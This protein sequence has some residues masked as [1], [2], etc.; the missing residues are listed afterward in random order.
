MSI[1]VAA[2]L[3]SGERPGTVVLFG[4]ALALVAIVLVSQSA[5]ASSDSGDRGRVAPVH[6]SGVT[7]ALMSGVAIGFFF[8]A[9]ARTAPAAGLW[10]L[11]AARAASVALFALM[12]LASGT[13]WRMPH[14][15]LGWALAGGALDMLA[16]ALYLVATHR[17]TLSVVVTLASLYPASTVMLAWLFLGER[18]SRVQA[19]GIACA[20]A[21]VILIVGGE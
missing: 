14:R 8:L 5:A 17:G 3:L 15:V 12:G 13:S 6:T 19:A 21:A 11:V 20:L 7:L 18:L 9:L 1:P 4:I 2:G 10:P 16:N